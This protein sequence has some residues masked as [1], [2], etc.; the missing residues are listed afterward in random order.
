MGEGNA[1]M[2]KIEGIFESTAQHVSETKHRFYTR[3]ELAVARGFRKTKITES[4]RRNN[5]LIK[6]SLFTGLDFFFPF[7]GRG[8]SVHISFTFSNTM[9]QWRSNALTLAKSFLLLRQLIR[10]CREIKHSVLENIKRENN[11]KAKQAI[12]LCCPET[13]CAVFS[14]VKL[15]TSSSVGVTSWLA[16]PDLYCISDHN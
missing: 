6:R 8:T 2:H 13:T 4:P 12:N 10:T 9:L 15:L 5:L 7:P 11:Q 3:A 14:L 1:S 16:V